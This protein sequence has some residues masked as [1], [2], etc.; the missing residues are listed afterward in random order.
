MNNLI[1][2][3]EKKF[4]CLFLLTLWSPLILF[5]LFIFIGHG[6]EP[7]ISALHLREM[8]KIEEPLAVGETWEE[9]LFTFSLKSV[10]QLSISE[11]PD[12][13]SALYNDVSVN[14]YELNFSFSPIKTNALLKDDFYL[15]ACSYDQESENITCPLDSNIHASLTSS[16][17][18]GY[19][20]ATNDCYYID[21][22][23]RVP[24]GNERY[25]KQVYR[26]YPENT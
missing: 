10:K 11:I 24:Y 25:F 21:I 26:F 3:R 19:I 22:I 20:F 12:I 4:W 7:I 23:I 5:G 6:F 8:N 15:Y 9:E 13:N 1:T 14:T 18:T 16:D 2:K 17:T